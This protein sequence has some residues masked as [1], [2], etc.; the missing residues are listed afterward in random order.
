VSCVVL[1]VLVVV[2]AASLYLNVRAV[3]GLSTVKTIYDLPL[4]TPFP[5]DPL[6]SVIIAARNE[7]GAIE[8]T[9]KKV[10]EQA[11]T[12]LE[13]IIVNDRSTDTTREVVDRVVAGYRSEEDAAASKRR[14]VVKDVESVPQGWLGKNHACHLGSTLT[15]PEADYLL[16]LDSDSRLEKTIVASVVR[17]A[18]TNDIGILSILPRYA[19]A[20]PLAWRSI[21][22]SF[23]HVLMMIVSFSILSDLLK[24][25]GAWRCED[26]LYRGTVTTGKFNLLSKKAY[27]AAGG[28]QAIRL[29]VIDDVYVAMQTKWHAM[30]R[31]TPIRSTFV[32]GV[33]LVQVDWYRSLAQFCRGTQKH[34]FAGIS[35]SVLRACVLSLAGG[36][37]YLLPSM[38]WMIAMT[39]LWSDAA[40]WA[41]MSRAEWWWVVVLSS[42]YVC[43]N[44]LF[45]RWLANRAF[46]LRV[47]DV[48][49]G[50]FA[51]L[52]AACAQYYAMYALWYSTVTVQRAGGV[53]WAGTLYPLT[54]LIDARRKLAARWGSARDEEVS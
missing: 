52:A 6:V 46:R 48:G 26:P 36:V 14:I 28:Y 3:Y 35:Y 22:T 21:F 41:G 7:E 5:H 23:N 4:V 54:Q 44:A 16:F 13:L 20:P 31:S 39:G 34:L 29:E 10:L 50:V 17:H 2:C 42:S 37:Y 18:C 33:D 45:L 25:T 30:R 49:M 27:D 19:P 11:Y 1:A 38:L 51:L 47:D 24:L 43:L 12:N 9:V 53:R 15:N 8:D 40:R 32:W